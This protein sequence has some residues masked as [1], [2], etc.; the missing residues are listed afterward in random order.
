MC[1]WLWLRSMMAL[2]WVSCM[3]CG[4]V[5][6]GGPI[7]RDDEPVAIGVAQVDITPEYPVR[8]YGYG[9][10][11]TESTG[12]AGRL[13][14][15]ALVIGDDAGEGPAVLL[16]VDSGA[17]PA[18]IRDDVF[19]QLQADVPL[20][21]ERFV[22]CNSH[23]HS[24]PDLKGM[25][26][27]VGEQREHLDRY[28]REVTGRLTQ[29]VRDALAARRPGRLAWT[30]GTVGFA[31]NRRVLKDG[32]W[33]GFGAVPDAPVDHSLPVL[34]VTDLDG[35]LRAVVLNYACHNT[36]L[37]GDFLQIHGDWAACARAAIEADQP[38]VVALV[39]VGCGADADPGPHGTVALCEQHGRAVADEVRRLLDQPW[40]PVTP[41]LTARQLP[42]AVPYDPLPPREELEQMAQNSYPVSRL[43]KMV[44]RGEVPP[45][46]KDYQVVTWVFGDDLA[47]VFLSDEVVVDYALRMKR[48]FDGSRLWISAYSHDV[49]NYVV[50]K[51]L[52]QEGGYEVNN[53]FSAMISYGHPERVQP[54]I[55]DRIVDHV[56]ALLPASFLHARP[57]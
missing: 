3:F 10:R 41:V 44:Q 8:M 24:G 1:N 26:A 36:T 56:R 39:T 53:S 23:N 32:Q 30:Q 38:G 34:R 14:A 27:L 29:V 5:S 17:V 7:E 18:S 33:A 47:M 45:T 51:R 13:E 2:V 40:R 50:S 43:L 28:A 48:E 54:P 31:T 37:R 21:V 11:Q 19:A 15:T 25:R 35:T 12:V 20:K 16:T 46:V 52:I 55:E 4:S 42:L 9:A 57:K 6:L 22:L 49:S